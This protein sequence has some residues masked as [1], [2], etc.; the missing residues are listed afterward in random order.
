MNKYFIIAIVVLAGLLAGLGKYAYDLKK[1]RDRFSENYAQVQKENKIL[2]EKYSDRDKYFNA[3]LDSVKKANKI[4]PKSVV[5]ATL[6]EQEY[7]DT[8]KQVITSGKPQIVPKNEVKD[9]IKQI[10]SKVLYKIPVS[11]DGKCWSM[12]GEILSRDPESKFIVTE[13]EFNNSVQAL[14]TR[15]R[16][17]GFLWYTKKQTLRVFSD[18]GEAKV[19][20]INYSK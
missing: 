10:V 1:D 15:K 3:K 18:C 6:I 11:V 7:K 5:S 8:T 14:I 4:K 19:T 20:Q 2:N 13:R 9:T 17:L 12:K 16:A